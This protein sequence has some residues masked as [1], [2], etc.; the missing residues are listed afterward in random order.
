MGSRSDGQLPL[1]RKRVAVVPAD[2]SIEPG[3]QFNRA[4]SA[5]ER[6]I[7]TVHQRLRTQS[8]GSAASPI[9]A[10]DPRP[11]G[12]ARG[13]MSIVRKA[14]ATVVAAAV[15]RPPEEPPVTLG[16][17]PATGVTPGASD[18]MKPEPEGS[19]VPWDVQVAVEAQKSLE[20]AGV[21]TVATGLLSATA[22]PVGLSTQLPVELVCAVGEVEVEFGF[23]GEP[24][25]A[26]ED[27]AVM[28][29]S[30]LWDDALPESDP[31]LRLPFVGE[32]GQLV[33]ERFPAISS[34][35]MLL[36]NLQTHLDA[37]E[38]LGWDI[39]GAGVAHCLVAVLRL[40][41][42]R[43]SRLVLGAEALRTAGIRSINARHLAIAA[44]TIA[45]LGTIVPLL[46]RA[47][48]RQLP[49]K[50]R[51]LLAGFDA[52]RSDLTAHH[53]RLLDKLVALLCAVS[54]SSMEA[55]KVELPLIQ[56]DSG[57]N[58]ISKAMTQLAQGTDKLHRI[59]VP[60]LS[61]REVLSLYRQIILSHNT[62][63]VETYRQLES[64]TRAGAGVGAGGGGGGGAG[65]AKR[66][67]QPPLSRAAR[68]MVGRDLDHYLRLSRRLQVRTG[69]PCR[70]ACLG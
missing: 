8:G 12:D 39:L 62:K 22:I 50:Q 25:R 27:G 44:Q 68:A 64:G 15:A 16:V 28:V 32:K 21:D 51:V 40:L 14:A 60:I 4:A 24:A 41:N 7:A 18:T 30:L 19:Y 43:S 61:P 56:E 46:K 11:E 65:D 20:S 52:V 49:P 69:A 45:L 66:S 70:V 63:L 54:V 2:P 9:S 48:E 47:M 5:R 31:G 58:S 34:M 29:L 42:E 57:E 33:T 53:D 67:A 26:A 13:V 10:G 6:A 3:A 59:L 55:V 38:C 23:R 36:G 37:A 1:K 35:L 17:T